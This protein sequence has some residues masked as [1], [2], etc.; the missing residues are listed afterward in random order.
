MKIL[1]TGDF[2]GDIRKVNRIAQ[3]AVDENVDLILLLGDML[4]GDQQIDG[5]IQPFVKTGKEVMFITGNHDNMAHN[6]MWE[7]MY[8]IKSLHGKGFV[9]NNIGIFG[10]SGCNVGVHQFTETELF[11]YL[12]NGNEKVKSA[13]KRIM[14]SHVH[15][16]GSTGE[17]LSAF[18]PGS[19]GVT[20]A[21]YELQPDIHICCHVHE[22]EGLEEKMGKTL[23]INTGAKGKVIEVWFWKNIRLNKKAKALFLRL[24]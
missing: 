7:T 4:H 14:V 6:D 11:N 23:V 12:K 2:H 24:L 8:K 15:P 10:T 22:A 9:R 17:K 18:I 13:K 1:A 5:L 19:L 3:K 16:S 21:I 20:K